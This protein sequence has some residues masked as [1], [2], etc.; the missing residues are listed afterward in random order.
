MARAMKYESPIHC[1]WRP[2][3]EKFRLVRGLAISGDDLDQFSHADAVV[4]VLQGA[5][6][7]GLRDA[8][9]LHVVCQEIPNELDALIVRAVSGHL[10]TGFEELVKILFPVG[11]E[12][13]PDASRLVQSQVVREP[14][15]HIDV[16]VE[17][18]QGVPQ[19]PVHLDA[20]GR[21]SASAADGR[22]SG[23][24]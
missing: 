20:P 3:N 2:E 4:M 21:P 23:P 7:A 15:R 19:D 6:L 16:M 11:H 22:I 13:G 18:D 14:S 24:N 10:R 1:L 9:S 17:R 8:C 5:A 12:K